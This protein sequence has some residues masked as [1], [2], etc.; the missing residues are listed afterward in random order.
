MI[1]NK[2]TK[3]YMINSMF[4]YFNWLEDG[5]WYIV[6]DGTELAEK[7]MI[8]YPRFNFVLDEN[9]EL[10][11]IVE[12]VKTQEEI[13]EERKIEIKS[14]LEILD[15]TINRATEDLYTLTNTMPYEKVAEV[16][17][18]KEILRQELKTLEQ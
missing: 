16:I 1:V 13:E 2:T 9:E 14:E 15:R 7:V 3:D 11:D 10:I 12:V 5:N 17:Q 4:P 8:L 18:Q 6:K